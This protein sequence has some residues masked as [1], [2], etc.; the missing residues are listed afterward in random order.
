MRHGEI[1]WKKRIFNYEKEMKDEF[2]SYM[3]D[4]Q[5]YFCITN[6]GIRYQVQTPNFVTN[7][8]KLKYAIQDTIDYL[9]GDGGSPRYFR[10]HD[11]VINKGLHNKLW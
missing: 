8:N 6:Y 11:K 10:L 9:E 1:L 4:I 7:S 2:G 5:V 3:F